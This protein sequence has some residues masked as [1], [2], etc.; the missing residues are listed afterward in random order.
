MQKTFRPYTVSVCHALD[1]FE[2]VFTQQNLTIESEN[3]LLP[4]KSMEIHR[5]KVMPPDILQ[6]NKKNKK[7]N[8]QCDA[9]VQNTDI[10]REDLFQQQNAVGL[11]LHDQLCLDRPHDQEDT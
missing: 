7:K 9:G 11:A 2:D 5:N 4:Y 3:S 10:L 8:K 6:K 1:T